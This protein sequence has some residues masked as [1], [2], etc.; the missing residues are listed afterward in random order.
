MTNIVK[1]SVLPN[2]PKKTVSRIVDRSR[3]M[4]RA[5][6]VAR[7]YEGDY[8]A[9]LALA[10]RKLY[11]NIGGPRLVASYKAENNSLGL[12]SEVLSIMNDDSTWLHTE[13]VHEPINIHGRPSRFTKERHNRARALNNGIRH[14]KFN[15]EIKFRKLNDAIEMALI[16]G[17][18]QVLANKLAKDLMKECEELLRDISMAE[19]F[20]PNR[21]HCEVPRSNVLD[22][23]ARN[24]CNK[25]VG[26][27][28]EINL[29]GAARFANIAI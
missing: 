5:H 29:S 17:P 6:A 2:A 21:V 16:E 10:M 22:M 20:V 27:Y 3:F 15:Y 14:I 18:K 12:C 11:I 25:L 19:S 8:I 24:F 7:T 4:K 1:T 9:C 28:E 26:T 13:I 23:H